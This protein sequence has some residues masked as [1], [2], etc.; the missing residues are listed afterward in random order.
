MKVAESLVTSSAVKLGDSESDLAQVQQPSEN[1]QIQECLPEHHKEIDVLPEEWR[2]HSASVA[3]VVA[4][5]EIVVAFVVAAATRTLGHWSSRRLIRPESVEILASAA[6]D[7]P[8]KIQQVS[9][10]SSA[11]ASGGAVGV[12]GE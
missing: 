10:R 12:V 11:K 4:S 7:W 8:C 6:A 1:Q 3:V 2:K 9:R 5:V